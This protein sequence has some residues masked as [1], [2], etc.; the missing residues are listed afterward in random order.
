MKH[1]MSIWIS[2]FHENRTAEGKIGAFKNFAVFTEKHLCWYLLLIKLQNFIKQDSNTGVSCEYCKM[3]KDS[4]LFRTPPV[5]VFVFNILLKDHYFWRHTGK[6]GPRPWGGTQDQRPYGGTLSFDPGVGPGGGTLG[7]DREVGL[8]GGT[9]G[10][11]PGVSQ[12]HL[13]L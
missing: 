9:L 1:M 12:P 8:C 2:S 4:F 13:I 6:V 7:W 10:W 5:A 3:F 11:E